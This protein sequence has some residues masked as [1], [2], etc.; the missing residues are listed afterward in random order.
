MAV[1]APARGGL[2]DVTVG[3]ARTIATR[4]SAAATSAKTDARPLA[5]FRMAIAAVGCIV[6]LGYGA[7]LFAFFS[8]DGFFSR[9]DLFERGVSAYR[10]CLLD[11]FGAPWQVF[12]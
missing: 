6:V 4:G 2:H 5:L 7:N 12:L 11:A 3:N 1:L 8:D 10:F 9:A